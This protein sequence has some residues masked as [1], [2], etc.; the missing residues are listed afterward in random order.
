MVGQKLVRIF[1]NM[2]VAA[3]DFASFVVLSLSPKRLM[4]PRRLRPG[5]KRSFDAGVQLLFSPVCICIC[6]THLFL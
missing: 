4:R 2:S 3:D 1:V 5:L 6:L